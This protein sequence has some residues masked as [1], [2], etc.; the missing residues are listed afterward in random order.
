MLANAAPA[1]SI[2]A[3]ALADFALP[4]SI[5]APAPSVFSSAIAIFSMASAIFL[6]APEIFLMIPA[7]AGLKSAVF[8]AE[9][10]YGNGVGAFSTR[11]P[12]PGG[13]AFDAMAG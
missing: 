2:F 9:V 1:L 8:L 12:S 7:G 13:A 3:A 10:G 5:F 11:F 4:I 6:F